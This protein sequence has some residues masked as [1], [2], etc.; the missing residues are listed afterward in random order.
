MFENTHSLFKNIERRLIFVTGRFPSCSF[1]QFFG[2]V[3]IVDI[4]TCSSGVERTG[5]VG[6]PVVFQ[7]WFE[8]GRK[9]IVFE[10]S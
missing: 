1:D 6:E 2:E 10:I 8:N 9:Q 4:K 7:I 5:Q 3:V